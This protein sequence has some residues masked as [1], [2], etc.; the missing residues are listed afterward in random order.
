[1]KQRVTEEDVD[2]N[3]FKPKFFES[4]ALSKSATKLTWDETDPDRIKAQRDA[5][6]PEANLEEL[7]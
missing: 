3:A 7:E 6:L 1:M 2:M 5:F 4:T